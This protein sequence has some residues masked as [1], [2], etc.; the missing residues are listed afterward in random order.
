M[1]FA[2]LKDKCY[3]KKIFILVFFIGVCCI[4]AMKSTTAWAMSP[5]LCS[6]IRNLSKSHGMDETRYIKLFNSAFDAVDKEVYDEYKCKVYDSVKK[7]AATDWFESDKIISD[8]QSDAMLVGN[9][10]FFVRRKYNEF[11]E[12]WKRMIVSYFKGQ[13]HEIYEQ[14]KQMA[15]NALRQSKCVSCAV[16]EEHIYSQAIDRICKELDDEE[17]MMQCFIEKAPV[18][19][20]LKDMDTSDLLMNCFSVFAPASWYDFSEMP[21]V[22]SSSHEFAEKFKKTIEKVKECVAKEEALCLVPKGDTLII[23]DLH[24]NLHSANIFISKARMDL[25]KNAVQSV[26]LLGDY[27]DRGFFSLEVLYSVFQLK[28]QFPDRVFLIRGNHEMKGVSPTSFSVELKCR[29]SQKDADDINMALFSDLF[30]RLPVA[31]EL[32]MTDDKK[33]L[34]VHGGIPEPTVKNLILFKSLKKKNSYDIA[35]LIIFCNTMTDVDDMFLSILWSDPKRH[36]DSGVVPRK[37]QISFTKD[38]LDVFLKKFGYEYLIRGHECVSELLK[39][40]GGKCCTVFSSHD[41]FAGNDARMAIATEK[42]L[43]DYLMVKGDGSVVSR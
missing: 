28:L 22:F 38:Q 40:F 29:L 34:C 35:P 18:A 36:D 12:Y 8:R 39:D 16:N 19:D 6:H 26:V 10:K 31:A 27:I 3:I 21:E 15:T 11:R 1:S 17:A 24:G 2:F 20:F 43:E 14:A 41:Y 7:C 23:G 25:E 4:A 13:G 32:T 42:G 9:I 33:I 30:P 5:D 37:G